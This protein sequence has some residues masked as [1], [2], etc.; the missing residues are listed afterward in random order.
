MSSFTTPLIVEPLNTKCW[1]LI[2]PFEYYT[3]TR[4]I[5]TIIKVPRGFITDFATVPRFLWT[6]FPPWDKY[7]K[8]AVIHDYIYKTER[9][10]RFL[11]DSIFFEAMTVLKV[12]TWKKELMYLA[13]RLFGAK[14]YGKKGAC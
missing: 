6:I 14:H 5:E 3:E 13:V 1:K 9:F 7:G 10:S 4:G 2:E 8:A 12:P 11:C